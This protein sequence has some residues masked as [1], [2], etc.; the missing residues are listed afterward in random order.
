M[1][2]RIVGGN[3]WRRRE[4]VE[5]V[6][7]PADEVMLRH[8]LEHNFDLQNADAQFSSMKKLYQQLST[9]LPEALQSDSIFEDICARF[10]KRSDFFLHW[11]KQKLIENHENKKM[12]KYA[13]KTYLIFNQGKNI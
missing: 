8:F 6:G 11:R 10:E 13:K 4:T 12:V 5:E 9:A 7:P 3:K 1:L 2:P